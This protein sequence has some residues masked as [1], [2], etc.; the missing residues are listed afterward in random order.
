MSAELYVV[1]N[2][3]FRRGLIAMFLDPSVGREH[4]ESCCAMQ[5][6]QAFIGNPK[7][8]LLRFVSPALRRIPEKFSTGAPVPGARQL[9]GGSLLS[10]ACRLEPCTS[11]TPAL[12][13]FT[14]GSTGEPKA[15]VRTHGFLLEQQ[16]VIEKSLQL[17]AGEIDLAT[18]P[19]F[20]LANLASGVT[21]LIPDADLRA[22]GSI[23]P[24]RVVRQIRAHRPHRMSASPAFLERLAD[25]CAETAQKL[26]C[27]RRIL[28]GGG[29][30]FPHLL[31][32]LHG[33]SPQ[34]EIVAVYGSTEAEPIAKISH[35]EIS[36][37]D[38]E[39]MWGGRGLLAG[40]PDPEVQIRILRETGCGTPNALA[41]AD[42]AAACVGECEPGQI[43]VSGPHVQ[44]GYLHGVGDQGTKLKVN[45]TTWH[46]TGDAGYLDARGRLWLLGRCS[47]RITDEKGTI[48]PFQVECAAHRDPE[49]RRAAL[50]LHQ[51]ERVL[52]VE[53]RND[54]KPRTLREDL[55]WAG[56]QRIRFL[57]RIPVDQRH[58]A[59]ICYAALRKVV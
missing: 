8:H 33:T 27:F 52:A 44:P 53:T 2:A 10:G 47:A 6:P 12:I 35:G 20:V 37:A 3:I 21:S 40:S 9:L 57:R 24:E 28:T 26:D 13:R 32:K 39:A 19:I 46:K 4:I 31:D 50:V 36:E 45:G 54:A 49:V 22:P 29:P 41:D 16:R 11:T 58:N 1:L 25:Y 38:R 5:P 55:D 56:I 30:V 42:F 43:A 34:A 18:L 51:G 59:K 7:A 17:V 23:R 15:A 48:Y 14:S